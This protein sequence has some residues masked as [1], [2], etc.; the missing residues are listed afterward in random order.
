MKPEP[1]ADEVRRELER[2][3]AP[4][5]I[6]DVVAAWP[7]AV[8]PSISRNA[9]PARIGRD[10][11]LHVSTSSSA[12][13][14]ELGLLEAQL[15]ER[16]DE[17]LGERAPKRL[18]FAPGRLPEASFPEGPG[19]ES[20]APTVTDQHVQAGEELAAAISDEN[21][22]KLVA[23]AAAASLARPPDDRSV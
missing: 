17:A 11:T 18:K 8:G 12:W 19:P 1:I 20:R 14:F 16:L 21:L 6:A 7:D 2:F 22:R 4:G 3:G 5:A 10:G 9:W 15:R 23:K 13:A